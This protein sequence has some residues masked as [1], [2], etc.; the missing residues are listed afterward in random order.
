MSSLRMQFADVKHFPD[1]YDSQDVESG[2]NE[3]WDVQ[4][5]SKAVPEKA[6]GKNFSMILPPPN[7]TGHLHLGH[8]LTATIQDALVRW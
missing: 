1:K 6:N 8:A 3:W 7:V 2:W 4:R 5:K